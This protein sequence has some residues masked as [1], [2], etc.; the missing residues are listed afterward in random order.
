MKIK[1]KI[2]SLDERIAISKANLA[3]I[4]WDTTGSFTKRLNDNLIKAKENKENFLKSLV[5]KKVKAT[6]DCGP[7]KKGRIYKVVWDRKNGKLGNEEANGK[8]EICKGQLAI[9]PNN[10]LGYHNHCNEIH[11]WEFLDD[12][13]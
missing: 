10:K 1:D 4:M 13:I 9:N 3:G 5:G 7:T 8:N 12:S 11:T 2:K 6:K